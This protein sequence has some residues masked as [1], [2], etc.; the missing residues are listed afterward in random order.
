LFSTSLHFFSILISISYKQKQSSNFQVK[1]ILVR[2][3]GT[4]LSLPDIKCWARPYYELLLIEKFL[5]FPPSKIKK[6]E[7]K[8]EKKKKKANCTDLTFHLLP[9]DINFNG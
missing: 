4:S 3:A 5:F 2:D 1:H 8:K 6:K 9:I 7:K